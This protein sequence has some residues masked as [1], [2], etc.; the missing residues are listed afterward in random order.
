MFARVDQFEGGVT[1]LIILF[2]GVEAADFAVKDW[3]EIVGWL[4]HVGEVKQADVAKH[5]VFEC[6]TF[7]QAK[8][9]NSLNLQVPAHRR[10]AEIVQ[11]EIFL[12]P[13]LVRLVRFLAQ[14]GLIKHHHLLLALRASQHEAIRSGNLSFHAHIFPL[15]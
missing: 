11:L 13:L 14:A 7:D 12:Q 1:L 4:Q 9:P 3:E 2:S 5:A 10:I 15:S 6:P 8:E